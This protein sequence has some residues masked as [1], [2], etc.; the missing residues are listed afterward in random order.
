MEIKIKSRLQ[1]VL[2]QK[3]LSVTELAAKIGR[4]QPQVWLYVRGEKIPKYG[5]QVLIAETLKTTVPEIWPA[6]VTQ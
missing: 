3:G 1:E 6:E 5:L 4:T 2:E